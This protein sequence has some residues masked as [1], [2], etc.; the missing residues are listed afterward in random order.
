MNA[1]GLLPLLTAMCVPAVLINACGLFILS[2][3]QR[4]G[5]LLERVRTLSNTAEALSGAPG[6]RAAARRKTTSVLMRHNSHRA[7]LL[8]HSLVAQYTAICLFVSAM[9][10]IAVV[11]IAGPSAAWAPLAL[12]F[13]GVLALFTA[14]VLLLVESREAYE[15]IR[16]ET[17]QALESIG[18]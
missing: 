3:A 13:G 2:T 18:G 7:R 1:E 6:E 11:H 15:T 16:R 10:G 4:M 14:S 12:A 5:R 9:I 8:H 17:A